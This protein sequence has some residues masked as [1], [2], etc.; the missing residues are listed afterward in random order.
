MGDLTSAPAPDVEHVDKTVQ[1]GIDLA[2]PPPPAVSEDATI[3]TTSPDPS[4]SQQAFVSQLDM[5]NN[6]QAPRHGAYNM[7]P[8]ASALPQVPYR[9]GQ[10]PP[11][12]QQRFNPA[13]SPPMMP[14]VAQMS[15]YGPSSAMPVAN[16]AYYAQ[17]PH[18]NHYYGGGQVSPNQNAN[19]MPSRQNMGYYP[20]QMMMGHN[21]SNF[22]YPAGAQYGAPG[23][24][25]PSATMQGQFMPGSPTNANDP[26]AMIQNSEVA[27]MQFQQSRMGLST[28][29]PDTRCVV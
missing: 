14:Q 17:Q 16:P 2:G 11:G 12:A 24:G 7:S 18:M 9:G 1:N 25:M 23:Q 27:Q 22:Y 10:Y 20:N 19:A 26:R 28:Y 6:S 3:P 29:I 15:Q 21:Q 5:T 13:A 4:N 8:M